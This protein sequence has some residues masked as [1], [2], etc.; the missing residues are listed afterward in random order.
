MVMERDYTIN[1]SVRVVFLLSSSHLT[2][3]GPGI[4]YSYDL[5]YGHFLS[6]FVNLLTQKVYGSYPEAIYHLMEAMRMSYVNLS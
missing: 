5:T 4:R 1:R 3:S 2:S 6:S